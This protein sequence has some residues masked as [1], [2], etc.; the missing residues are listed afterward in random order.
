MKR[1]KRR[2]GVSEVF[3]PGERSAMKEAENRRRG[4]PMAAT[5]RAELN[6]RA[7]SKGIAQRL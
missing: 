5:L 6:D 2:P 3:L 7:A 4:F 1:G